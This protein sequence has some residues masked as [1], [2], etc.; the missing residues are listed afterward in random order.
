MSTEERVLAAQ[1]GQLT[2]CG[3]CGFLCGEANRNRF[4]RC[5][6]S[7]GIPLIATRIES[8][9]FRPWQSSSSLA[10]ACLGSG[11]RP[12]SR[13]LGLYVLLE[14]GGRSPRL[15]DGNVLR[16]GAGANEVISA[17]RSPTSWKRGR[18]RMSR[19]TGKAWAGVQAMLTATEHKN[20]HFR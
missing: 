6:Q 12:W 13:E 18:F 17:G 15:S 7:G 8:G 11:G 4:R 20:L 16:S 3:H 14:H 5:R 2:I 1:Y 10:V 19:L 9:Q